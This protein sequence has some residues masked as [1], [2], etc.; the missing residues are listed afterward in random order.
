M[1]LFLQDV[2]GGYPLRPFQAE[3]LGALLHRRT[4]LAVDAAPGL[5]KSLIALAAIVEALQRGESAVWLMP[6]RVLVEEKAR[7]LSHVLPAKCGD[8]CPVVVRLGQRDQHPGAFVQEQEIS[9]VHETVEPQVLITTYEWFFHH[10]VSAF[11][12]G[13]VVLDEAQE[14]YTPERGEILH[15]IIV[16]LMNRVH[17]PRITMLGHAYSQDMRLLMRNIE[18]I[19]SPE[20]PNITLRFA[21]GETGIDALVRLLRQLFIR[22]SRAVVAVFV[23]QVSHTE[24]LAGQLR[25]RLPDILGESCLESA[26]PISIEAFHAQLDDRHKRALIDAVQRGVPG[27]TISTTAL[28]KGIDLPFTE[29]I[30]RDTRLPGRAALS[31]PELVQLGARC[32]RRGARGEVIVLRPEPKNEGYPAIPVERVLLNSL[33][34]ALCFRDKSLSRL[35]EEEGCRVERGGAQEVVNALNRL[36]R[37]GAVTTEGDLCHVTQVGRVL[38][39]APVPLSWSMGWASFFKEV[40]TLPLTPLDLVMVYAALSCNRTIPRG[41]APSAPSLLWERWLSKGRWEPFFVTLGLTGEHTRGGQRTPEPARVLG[42][43]RRLWVLRTKGAAPR[44]F[45]SLLSLREIIMKS[46]EHCCVD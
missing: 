39:E 16:S 26:P 14:L 22:N 33:L 1:E 37:C 25:K 6:L 20:R 2:A 42:E 9:H 35:M 4:H 7:W 38:F 30:V 31:M 34:G 36:S 45:D 12:K 15:R 18:V 8:R 40:K 41:E 5:G 27:V 44:G 28:A 3:A 13:T 46:C 32:G 19:R 10:H 11:L 21:P 29:V 43:T 24:R 23:A 17:V